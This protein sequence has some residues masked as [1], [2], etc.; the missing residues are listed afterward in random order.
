LTGLT[1]NEFIREIRLQKAYQLLEE[2]RYF[3]VAE[4]RYATG[5]ENA[6]YFTKVFSKRFGQRPGDILK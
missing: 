3:T 2:R 1:P 5:F 6:S 4:V